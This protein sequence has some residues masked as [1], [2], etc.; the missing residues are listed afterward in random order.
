MMKYCVLNKYTVSI[1]HA[2]IQY[3]YRPRAGLAIY[4]ALGYVVCG[5][6]STSG[7][8]RGV[9]G[10]IAPPKIFTNIFFSYTFFY[11]MIGL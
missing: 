2:T 7:G 10:A 1:V 4:G 6:P 5:G 9:I 11:K 8:S 3:I